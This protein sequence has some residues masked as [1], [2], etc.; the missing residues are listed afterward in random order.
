METERWRY[1]NVEECRNAASQ[2]LVSDWDPRLRLKNGFASSSKKLNAE[3]T[4]ALSEMIYWNE[5][6][7]QRVKKMTKRMSKVWLEFGRQRCRILIIQKGSRRKLP[8]DKLDQLS[9]SPLELGITPELVVYGNSKGLELETRE[10][11]SKGR[12]VTLSRKL[13]VVTPDT[14]WNQDYH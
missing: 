7:D 13:Q 11:M 6:V 14:S 10:T 8:I 9:E 12:V 2:K 4:A 5:D 1:V 3:L